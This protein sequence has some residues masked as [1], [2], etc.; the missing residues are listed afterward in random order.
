MNSEEVKLTQFSHGGGCGCK[1]SPQVLEQIL[2][3]AKDQSE[4]PDLHDRTDTNCLHGGC[5]RIYA[6]IGLFT[7]F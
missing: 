3:S 2:S 7:N 1:I 6:D 4:F 5:Y